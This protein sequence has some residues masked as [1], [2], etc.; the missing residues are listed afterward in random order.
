MVNM[1]FPSFLFG[2]CTVPLHPSWL[3]SQTTNYEV[4]CV[5][6]LQF[7]LIM[8]TGAISLVF[9]L[10]SDKRKKTLLHELDNFREEMLGAGKYSESLKK[11]I[12]R[13]HCT[14]NLFH[15]TRNCK[16]FNNNNVQLHANAPSIQN[17]Y[18]RTNVNM[19]ILIDIFFSSWIRMWTL[20][21]EARRNA[22][23]MP[24]ET[25]DIELRRRG[26]C[27]VDGADS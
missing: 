25:T 15:G 19:G 18:D 6:Q 2:T 7:I 23:V 9:T 27:N 13:I 22:H 10:S 8:M 11:L 21:E 14:I 4:H 24:C 5:R 16:I 26:V 17:I 20:Y 12:T 1:Y 3:G